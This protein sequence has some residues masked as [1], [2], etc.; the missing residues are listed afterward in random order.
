[1][2]NIGFGDALLAK[3]LSCIL[4]PLSYIF[5]VEIG[6][7]MTFSFTLYPFHDIQNSIEI[8]LSN[9]NYFLRNNLSGC[10]RYQMQYDLIQ[11][12]YVGANNFAHP[13]SSTLEDTG[14]ALKRFAENG[15]T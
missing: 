5:L 1:M 11:Q 9:K 8:V 15:L 2:M 4:F 6:N 3:I 7:N 14:W 12:Q 13:V 10:E